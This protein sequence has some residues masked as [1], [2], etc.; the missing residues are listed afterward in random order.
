[1][2]ANYNNQ[3]RDNIK[4]AIKIILYS[5]FAISLFTLNELKDTGVRNLV[6][7]LFILSALFLGILF[8]TY[9]NIQKIKK[10][11]LNY[12]FII[13]Y[14][15]FFILFTLIFIRSLYFYLFKHGMGGGLDFFYSLAELI[16][17]LFSSKNVLGII[18]ILFIITFV[19]LIKVI[20]NLLEKYNKRLSR[21]EGKILKKK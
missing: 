17:Q 20:K 7:E 15:P 8:F 2:G 11:L 10:T 3:E 5:L 6:I 16:R 12:I 18:I 13:I 21:L 4:L 9:V 1:M 19:L 14:T